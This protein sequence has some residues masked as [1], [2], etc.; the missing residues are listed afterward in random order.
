M[1]S[2]LVLRNSHVFRGLANDTEFTL[3][4][5]IDLYIE[6]AETRYMVYLLDY[7][8][9]YTLFHLQDELEQL[10]GF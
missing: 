3:F 2:Y 7:S 10:L 5:L 6:K 8:D 9:F 4:I 1:G